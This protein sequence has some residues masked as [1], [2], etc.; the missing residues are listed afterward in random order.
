MNI[1][2]K[3]IQNMR[4]VWVTA[5]VGL[6][7]VITTEGAALTFEGASKP[8]IQITPEAQTGLEVV[9][10]LPETTGVRAVYTASSTTA[11]VSWK[12]FS[13]LGGGYAED[14]AFSHDGANSWINLANG[15]DMGYIV[16][17]DGRQHA[18]WVVNY[19]NHTCT[20]NALE[21]LPEQDCMTAALRLDGNAA[22]INY[23]SINGARRELSREL[24]LTYSTQEYTQ[25]DESGIGSYQTIETSVE[26]S[27]T[28][29]EIHCPA[30]L[31]DTQFT[32]SGDRFQQQWGE[33]H[34]VTSPTMQTIAIEAHAA[35]TQ[36]QREADNEQNSGADSGTLGGSAPVT[37]DFEAAITDAVIFKEWQFARD[38]E[39]DLIDLRVNEENV[40]QTFTEYGTTYVRFV[41]GNAAGTCDYTSETFTVNVGESRLECP[42]AFS[43]N[44]DGVNDQWKV[45]YKSI[46][47]FD[48][49][50]FNRWGQELAHLTDP[51]QGWDGKYNGKTV[52]PGAY[53][54]VITARGA[55]GRKYKLSGDINI[56][57]Y[58]RNQGVTESE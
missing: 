52:P 14:V 4:H 58:K 23:Y 38:A 25:P 47:S 49:H 1:P 40:T 9:Y 42:N 55:D 44:D 32:L 43:P 22:P 29:G 36:Q 11:A 3:P 10:M 21:I 19:A 28:N 37:I 56:I 18:F 16:E 53:Y 27:S 2:I 39:F 46:I 48:C 33:S 30:P 7:A 17:E 45:S 20:L 8:A 13:S 50:I 6:T 51:S 24:M 34:H 57:H 31:C 5:L 15:D 54:Y 35:A 41:A 26:L 12:R